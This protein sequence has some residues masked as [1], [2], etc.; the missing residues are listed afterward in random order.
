MNVRTAA[1][2]RRAA[3]IRRGGRAVIEVFRRGWEGHPYPWRFA[4]TYRGVRIEFAG[5]PNQCETKTEARQRAKVRA[6]WL[7]R[8]FFGSYY[9]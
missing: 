9:K 2:R 8:G 1:K 7:E 6:R 4:V 5:L 3:N